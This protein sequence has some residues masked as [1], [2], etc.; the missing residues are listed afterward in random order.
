MSCGEGC[1][2]KKRSMVSTPSRRLKK[3][4]TASLRPYRLFHALIKPL[5]VREQHLASQLHR[6]RSPN[7]NNS[8]VFKRVG[9]DSILTGSERR[10]W[11]PTVLLAMLPVQES[12]I[13]TRQ[14]ASRRLK[15]VVQ[16]RSTLRG[17]ISVAECPRACRHRVL[18]RLDIL[19]LYLVDSPRSRR[20]TTATLRV[21]RCGR[22]HPECLLPGE[23]H[24]SATTRLLQDRALSVPPSSLAKSS[25]T[26]T[27]DE[28]NGTMPG[29]TRQMNPRRRQTESVVRPA[30]YK[31]PRL[32]AMRSSPCLRQKR[33]HSLALC[34]S[35]KLHPKSYP[36]FK[37]MPRRIRRSSAQTRAEDCDR[38]SSA[39]A[40]ALWAA[41]SSDRKA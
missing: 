12:T 9:Q 11:S 18:H 17:A 31:A 35:S 25:L 16:L 6:R 3:T 29:S 26:S 2:K 41:S 30:R 4:T 36:C 38:W 28:A 24:H 39:E 13:K 8:A 23:R 7:S 33:L 19:H 40:P 34:H 5:S 10:R 14:A 37:P 1:L 32:P 21:S 15:A 27:V 20:V 22:P